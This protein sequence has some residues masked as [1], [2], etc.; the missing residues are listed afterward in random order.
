MSVVGSRPQAS[1]WSAW[2]RPISPPSAVTAALL[3]MFCGL[4]GATRRPFRAKARQRPATIIDLPT[5]EPAPWIIS[6][7]GKGQNST[8]ACA[9]TPERKGCLTS[10]I[11]VTRSATSIN[12]SLA[13]RPVSTTWVMGGFAVFSNSTTSPTSR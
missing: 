2:A 12:S 9:F 11:S 7:A 6:A 13:L 1:A 5:F 8:P 10:S 4:K 3:D